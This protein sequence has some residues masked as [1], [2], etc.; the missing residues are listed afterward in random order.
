MTSW[1]G[2]E[3]LVVARKLLLDRFHDVMRHEGL[4]VIFANVPVGDKAGLAAQIAGELPTVVVLDNDGVA[5]ALQQVE[6]RVPMQRDEPSYRQ[7]IGGD[8]RLPQKL[9]GLVNHPV[10]RAPADQCD[11]RVGRTLEL[12]RWDRGRNAIHLAHA[13]FHHGAAL[14]GVR[15]FVADQHAVFIVLVARDSMSMAGHTGNGARGNSA[16][17]DFVS[18]VGF[19]FPRSI[20][21]DQFA[22]IDG[23]MEVELLRDR[24]LAALRKASRSQS[25][26]PGHW[27]RSATL[28]I[29]GISLKQSAMSRGAAMTLG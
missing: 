28:N 25:T 14:D 18:L 13:L 11:V 20:R 2:T 15:V 7:M 27:K 3:R 24:R 26:I 29:S 1:A 6:D 22:A 5:R 21:S 10:G 8:T 12:R 23:W 17:G 19:V 9:A 16:L 4:S